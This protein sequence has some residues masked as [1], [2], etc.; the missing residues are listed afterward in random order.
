MQTKEQLKAELEAKLEESFEAY[1]AKLRAEIEHP[2]LETFVPMLR[3]LF[4]TGF[5]QGVDVGV[6]MA[7]EAFKKLVAETR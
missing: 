6:T 4:E 5:L 2:E 1:M 7:Q 3:S